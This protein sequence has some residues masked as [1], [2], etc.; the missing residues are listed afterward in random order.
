MKAKQFAKAILRRFPTLKY[1][2][3]P[4]YHHVSGGSVSSGYQA[5]ADEQIDTVKDKLT[6]SWQDE[7]IPL[8]QRALVERQL[9]AYRNSIANP[10][11]DALTETLR[12]HIP[13]INGSS[14]LEIGCSSGYYSEVLGIKGILVNYTGCDYSEAFVRLARQC[15]PTVPF[16]VDDAV[17]LSYRSE[18]FDVVVSGCCILH[19]AA[20]EKA[21]SEAARVSKRYV[22]FHRTPVLHMHGPVYYIKKAY[23]VETME[24]HF[25][26][27]QLVALFA[28]HGMRVIAAN[29]HAVSWDTKQ[30]DALAMKT[31]LCE[32]TG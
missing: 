24:I 11:F 3:L 16:D 19:I 30:Q 5:V 7:N 15:Y 9:E 6:L 27:Q 4:A 8:R 23:D 28:A 1:L 31:Y 17:N 14:L 2:V 20:Y 22:M 18:S 13:N 12:L 21:I 29:T 10:V 26:E 25:H 32:K